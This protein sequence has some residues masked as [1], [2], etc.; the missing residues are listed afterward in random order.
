VKLTEDQHL[1][2]AATLEDMIEQQVLL[3]GGDLEDCRRIMGMLA[4]S[5]DERSDLEALTA[6]S[7]DADWIILPD[8]AQAPLPRDL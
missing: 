5:D 7:S 8:G 4:A 2:M 1:S 3:T 6:E